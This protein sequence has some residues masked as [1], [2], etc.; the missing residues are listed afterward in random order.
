MFS[1]YICEIFFYF[2]VK[3][4]FFLLVCNT[5]MWSS[6][7]SCLF[8]H[9]THG[10][11][12]RLL[13]SVFSTLHKYSQTLWHRN[14][15]GEV[16][17]II[18]VHLPLF[19]YDLFAFLI[20]LFWFSCYF[21]FAVFLVAHLACTECLFSWT[22]CDIN[23]ANIDLCSCFDFVLFSAHSH[24]TNDHQKV[25]SSLWYV[26]PSSRLDFFARSIWCWAWFHSNILHL[27][28]M[29]RPAND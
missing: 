8:G 12:E 10:T 9:K 27:L 14:A 24:T 1:A 21:C 3:T 22:L 20:V 25:W 15:C 29:A 26:H 17:K 13:V 18:L 11:I 7:W 19:L 6:Y 4:S 5:V 2:L 23:S 16:S 28:P